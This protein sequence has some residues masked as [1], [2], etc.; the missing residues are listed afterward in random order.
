[1]E[2]GPIPTP[3]ATTGSESRLS[4]PR[5]RCQRWEIS[6]CSCDGDVI[7]RGGPCVLRAAAAAA[8]AGIECSSRHEQK[9][10]CICFF[11]FPSVFLSFYL[12]LLSLPA[13]RCSTRTTGT[14]AFLGS[15]RRGAVMWIVHASI[16]VCV[17]YISATAAS[18]SPFLPPSKFVPLLWAGLSALPTACKGCGEKARG[19]A[20]NRDRGCGGG[21]LSG[22]K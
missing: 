3:E 14:C 9:V 4:W 16:V 19:E 12:S 20:S 8:S 17:R 2:F 10:R 22:G 21:T 13:F 1:M 7:E 15:K 5:P 11:L 6:S 18:F